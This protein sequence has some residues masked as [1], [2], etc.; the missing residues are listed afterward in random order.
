MSAFITPLTLLDVATI[1]QTGNAETIDDAFF[2]ANFPGIGKS[3]S[4]WTVQVSL[5]VTDATAI[6]VD[7]EGSIDKTLY[8][9]LASNSLSVER[10]AAGGGIFHIAQKPVSTIR[11]NL[12]TIGGGTSPAVTVKILPGD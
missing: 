11:A 3:E 12:I 4:R 9:A 5:N 7:I 10:L 1:A 8:Q 2:D 6:T